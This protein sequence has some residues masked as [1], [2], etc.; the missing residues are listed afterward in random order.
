[1]FYKSGVVQQTITKKFTAHKSNI[2]Q[3]TWLLVQDTGQT[4]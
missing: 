4:L 1:M 2:N 3:E